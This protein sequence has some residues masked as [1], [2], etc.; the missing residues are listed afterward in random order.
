M[1][2]HHETSKQLCWCQEQKSNR[3]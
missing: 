1:T 2:V 3:T